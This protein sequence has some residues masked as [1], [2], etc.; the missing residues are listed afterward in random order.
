MAPKALVWREWAHPILTPGEGLFSATS[1]SEKLWFP[2]VATER[3]HKDGHLT[4]GLL[5]SWVSS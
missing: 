2:T 4:H 5:I 1:Q 3:S